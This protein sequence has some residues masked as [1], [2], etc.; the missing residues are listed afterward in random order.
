MAHD[1]PLPTMRAMRPSTAFDMDG[2]FRDRKP[3]A[4]LSDGV[5]FTRNVMEQTSDLEGILSG[6]RTVSS[7]VKGSK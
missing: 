7:F 5:M 4:F 1:S 3:R 2:H 6:K